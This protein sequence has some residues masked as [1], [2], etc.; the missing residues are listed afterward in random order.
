MSMDGENRIFNDSFARMHGY[1]SPEEMEHL[2]LSDL[3]TPETA[4]LAQERM[5]RLIAGESMNF[6]VEHYHKDGHGFPLSVAANVVKIDGVPHFLGFHRDISDIKNAHAEREALLQQLHQSQKMEAIGQLAGGIAHDF[7]NILA[8]I[9]GTADQVLKSLPET[10]QSR[11]HL[12][13]ITRVAN[14]AKDLTLHLLTFARKEKLDI[15][16][17]RVDELIEELIDLLKRSLSKNIR[18]HSDCSSCN[19]RVSMDMNQMVQALLNV[20]LNAADAMIEGGTLTINCIEASLD[21]KE[22][23]KLPGI[24]PG[25]YSRIV[26]IDNGTGMPED[27]KEQIFT[28]FF[29]TKERGKG[30]GLGLPIALGIVQSHGGAIAID[31]APGKGTRV[32]IYMPVSEKPAAIQATP[33]VEEQRPAARGTILVVDDDRD[34]LDM[35]AEILQDKGFIVIPAFGPARAIELFRRFETKTDLVILDMMMPEMGGEEVFRVLRKIKPDVKVLVCSGYSRNGK[36]GR[37]LTE[38]A[39]G[40]LQKPFGSEQLVRAVSSLML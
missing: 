38:G 27:V 22:C 4:R 33:A 7:N 14:R 18:I 10:G 2:R 8:V 20:C 35:T 12:E 25:R 34:F 28:P 6:E 11:K 5:N 3:D 13:R 23:G 16:S 29:T 31:S 40:F 24:A 39:N 15:R 36:A 32:E 30:T 1:N 37:I 21:M 9:L 19:S 26:I 17:I